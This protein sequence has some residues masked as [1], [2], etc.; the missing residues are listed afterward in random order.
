V[1]KE[2]SK[3]NLNGVGRLMNCVYLYENCPDQIRNNFDADVK[4]VSIPHLVAIVA[5]CYVLKSMILIF[6]SF[7]E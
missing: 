7:N 2:R 3:L 1:Q 4:G 6:L 5:N